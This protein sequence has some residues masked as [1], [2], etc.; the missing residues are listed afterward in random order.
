M[1]Y[2]V[3][4]E[5]T[6]LFDGELYRVFTVDVDEDAESG[7]VLYFVQYKDGDE[8]DLDAIECKIAVEYHRKI[9]SGEI[10]EWEIGQE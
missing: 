9:E 5:V 3:G 10:K 2:E 6:K 4:T 7:D 1:I 8:E